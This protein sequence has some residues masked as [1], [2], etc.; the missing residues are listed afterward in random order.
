MRNTRNRRSII[1]PESPRRRH[2]Q[3]IREKYQGKL[4]P[5]PGKQIRVDRPHR[6]RNTRRAQQGTVRPRPANFD[7]KRSAPLLRRLRRRSQGSPPRMFWSQDYHNEPWL[8]Y[9]K[10]ELPRACGQRQPDARR[11]ERGPEHSKG[12]HE[13]RASNS[14]LCPQPG[15]QPCQSCLRRFTLIVTPPA[16]FSLTAN[17][18]GLIIVS[19]TSAASTISISPFNGFTAPVNLNATGQSGFTTSL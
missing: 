16:D 8:R 10:S 17:P 6:S 15:R 19:C 18:A 3:T 9:W 12:I 7:T 5:K 2:L 13:D 11:H 14:R 1:H 4:N